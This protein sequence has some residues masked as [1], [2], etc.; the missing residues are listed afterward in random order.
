[1][2]IKSICIFFLLLLFLI[3]CSGE[4]PTTT[5]T[6]TADRTAKSQNAK[7]EIQL[8]YFNA[9]PHIYID[10]NHRLTGAI[11]DFIEEGIA[12]EMGVKFNWN[13]KSTS[14]PRQ[15][16]IIKKDAQSAIALLSITEER[17]KV[18]AFTE[19]PYFKEPSCTGGSANQS[20]E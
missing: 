19:A 7:D 8:F 4:Q 14:I 6:E 17:T 12:P 11:V 1:M 16:E 9:P 20:A 10:A 15:I 13:Q 2:M 5:G 18:M 3:G